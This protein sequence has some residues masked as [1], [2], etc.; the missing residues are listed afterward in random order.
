MRSSVKRSLAKNINDGKGKFCPLC[1][2]DVALTCSNYD[3]Q[4][5]KYKGR[6]FWC[7]ACKAKYLYL[8]HRNKFHITY[9]RYKLEACDVTATYAHPGRDTTDSFDIL[10]RTDIGI[11][12]SWTYDERITI[13]KELNFPLT[14]EELQDRVTL[15]LTFS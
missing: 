12:P 5:K 2:S 3:L 10:P 6:E 15:Y 4:N 14:K 9:V 7:K 13:E 1:C 8:K 11:Y